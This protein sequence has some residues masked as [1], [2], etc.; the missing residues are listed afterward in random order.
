[1]SIFE[2]KLLCCLSLS[3]SACIFEA[4]AHEV[5]EPVQGSVVAAEASFIAENNTAMEKMMAGMDTTPTGNIDRDFVTSM[6]AHHQGAID[7]AVTMLKY[8]HNEHLKR[9]AQ[10]IIVD[11]QQ[12]I[13]AMRQALGD[14]LPPSVAS[15]TQRLVPQP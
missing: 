13:A 1:M 11:Q 8:G 6:S 9:M 2:K 3:F 14:P 12:E 5:H 7:M 15:P 4:R 10:E